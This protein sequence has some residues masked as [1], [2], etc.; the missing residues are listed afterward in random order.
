MAVR[1]HLLGALARDL[2]LDF[3]K[4]PLLCRRDKFLRGCK[5]DA[6]PGTLQDKRIGGD[7]VQP[8]TPAGH[9][10]IGFGGAV[11]E[12]AIAHVLR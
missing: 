3:V 10:P 7:T 4:F 8:T 9:I 1:Q 12:K 6:L 11:D 2:Q 5:I